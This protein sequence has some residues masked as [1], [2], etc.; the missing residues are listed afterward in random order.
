M[1]EDIR[2]ASCNHFAWTVLGRGQLGIQCPL[3]ALSTVRRFFKPVSPLLSG[4]SCSEF[5]GNRQLRAHVA[6]TFHASEGVVASTGTPQ[7]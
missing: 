2:E 7:D 6:Q 5:L 1:H 3:Q 4:S